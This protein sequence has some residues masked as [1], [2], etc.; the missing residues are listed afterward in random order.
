M[1]TAILR[2]GDIVARITELRCTDYNPQEYVK[3]IQRGRMP[4]LQCRVGDATCLAVEGP[5]VES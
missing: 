1:R 5:R 2:A 3:V 4:W